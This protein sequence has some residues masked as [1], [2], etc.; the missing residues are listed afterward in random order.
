MYAHAKSALAL[1]MT[2]AVYAQTVVDEDKVNTE[3]ALLARRDVLR[4]LQFSREQTLAM[5]ESVQA[6]RT[7]RADPPLKKITPDS[8]PEEIERHDFELRRRS[9]EAKKAVLTRDQLARLVE[10]QWQYESIGTLTETL[11]R[12]L[13]LTEE[14]AKSCHAK[15]VQLGVELR[16]S[17][18]VFHRRSQV[19]LHDILTPEQREEWKKLTGEEFE[20]DPSSTGLKPLG[21]LR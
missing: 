11:A 21:V 4:E 8:S 20:F 7:Q 10:L 6:M 2:M 18:L 19:E 17:M 1:L 9:L 5:L 13:S 14:Q 16:E 12:A 3:S 15:E